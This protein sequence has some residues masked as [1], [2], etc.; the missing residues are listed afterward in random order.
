MKSRL[1]LL[2][3]LVALAIIAT[4]WSTLW[5]V[6]PGQQTLDGRVQRVASQ[7]KCLVCQGES[8][9]DSPS[10][11]AQQMRASI[12]QQLQSGRSEQDVIQYFEQR[13]GDQI[14]WSPPWQ[15]FSLLAWLVPLAFLL[16]GIG[17]IILLLREWRKGIVETGSVQGTGSAQGTTPTVPVRPR[18]I[19][20]TG[21]APVR[22]VPLQQR[23]AE[24]QSLDDDLERYRAQVEAELAEDDVLFRKPGSA[25]RITNT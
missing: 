11:L 14:V 12:R 18:N 10:A 13:Y 5:I 19:V 6:A 23:T 3:V 7:L 22:T 17:L 25:R 9:A 8:V 20:G 4:V 24:G 21:L 1:P 16:C 15:G 2:I